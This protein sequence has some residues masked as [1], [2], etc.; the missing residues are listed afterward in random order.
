M[1]PAN[2]P[3]LNQAIVV[4]QDFLQKRAE[5]AERILMVLVDSLAYTLAPMNKGIVTKTMMR[6]I[7][8]QRS[9]GCRGRL[10]GSADQHRAQAAPFARSAAQY[11]PAHGH[12]KSQSGK[13]QSGRVDRRRLIR[14][15]D[16]NGFIEKVAAT[17][18]LN[19]GKFLTAEYAKVAENIFSESYAVLCG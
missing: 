9:D 13:C 11:S 18:G 10:S 3:M 4:N 19:R 2:I 7:A 5:L 6:R 8:N 16:E 15:L 12:A 14:K 17:Y 1:T